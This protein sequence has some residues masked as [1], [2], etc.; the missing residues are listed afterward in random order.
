MLWPGVYGVTRKLFFALSLLLVFAA[1]TI[2]ASAS[3]SGAKDALAQ[4]AEE[5]ETAGEFLPDLVQPD[6]P[7]PFDANRVLPSE[8][9]HKSDDAL[10]TGIFPEIV[11]PPPL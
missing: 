5:L 4:E 3:R 2:L 8:I 1:F 11:T 9:A 7:A 6:A 10:K